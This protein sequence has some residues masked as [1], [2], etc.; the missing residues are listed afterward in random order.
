MAE[1]PEL[2][3]LI[4]LCLSVEPGANPIIQANYIE[5][6]IALAVAYDADSIVDIGTN[7]GTSCLSFVSAMK[8]MGKPTSWVATVDIHHGLW[9]KTVRGFN[10]KF[11][12]LGIDLEDIMEIEVDFKQ[13]SGKSMIVLAPASKPAIKTLFFYDIHDMEDGTGEA[14]SPAF[15][16]HWI[17]HMEDALVLIHDIVPC[18]EDWERPKEWGTPCSQSKAQHWEGQWFYGNGECGV[19]IDFLNRHLTPIQIVPGTSIVYFGVKDGEPVG[20]R[21]LLTASG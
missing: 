6:M 11:Q 1:R 14:N 3:N 13:L 19:F 4:N 12:E 7:S 21:D 5:A 18:E 2:S 16:E 17:P 8:Y 9:K 15:I 20:S 10:E